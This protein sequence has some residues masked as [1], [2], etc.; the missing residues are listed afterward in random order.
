M[1]HLQTIVLTWPRY[2]QGIPKTQWIE[3][4]KNILIDNRGRDNLVKFLIVKDGKSG[5]QTITL[6]PRTEDSL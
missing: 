5:S 3:S 1:N 6:Q 4:L 2:S